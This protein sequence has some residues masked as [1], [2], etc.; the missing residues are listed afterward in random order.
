L[1]FAYWPLQMALK[2][3]QV[4]RPIFAANVIAIILMFTVG[5]WM[6]QRW[7]VYGTIAGQALNALVVNVILW[8]AWYLFRRNP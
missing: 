5:I 7:G 8:S 1:W 2:A 3:V 6:I 4:S